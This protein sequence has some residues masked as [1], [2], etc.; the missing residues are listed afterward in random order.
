VRW[1]EIRR[2]S[3]DPK[4]RLAEMELDM[5][6]A[7]VLYPSLVPQP[8]FFGEDPTLQVA[9]VQAYNDWIHELSSFAPNRLIGMPMAPET[10]VD[11]VLAELR[12]VAARGDRGLLITGY[13]SGAEVPTGADDR[14]W[15]EAQEWDYAIHIHFGFAN[16]LKLTSPTGV[17]YLTSAALIDM[18]A[19]MYRPLADLVYSGVFERFPRLR[20]V[21][22]EAGIG[23]IPYFLHHLDDNF[24]RRRFRADVHL[25]RMPSEYFKEHVWATFI[26][27]PPGIRQRHEI[28]VDRIMWSTD[29]PHTNSNWPNSQRIVSY[30]FRDVPAAERRMIM[31]DNAAA[32][33][34]LD[35]GSGA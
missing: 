26:E 4:A 11:D 30:E 3:Y 31:R 33:Y 22:V 20:I 34:G 32:L 14:F 18:G 10:G 12:R 7:Q 28:G 16:S 8:K 24:L 5:I 1:D 35:R 25:R 21:A 15:A 27:D 2:A 23:W 29:Y 6:E 17:G 9:C 19:A 13:P